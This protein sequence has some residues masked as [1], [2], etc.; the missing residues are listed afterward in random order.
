M[1][2]GLALGCF[3]HLGVIFIRI[4]LIGTT[5]RNTAKF[6]PT[7]M[8]ITAILQL[9]HK[10]LPITHLKLSI[11]D[12]II[13]LKDIA[14]KIIHRL[15]ILKH[16]TPALD[17]D[18]ILDHFPFHFLKFFFRFKGDLLLLLLAQLS[19]LLLRVKE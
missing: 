8:L 10:F 1:G 13:P 14:N 18:N 2:L 7:I 16:V 12:G 4:G 9:P 19:L 6:P 5:K 3:S 11:Q 17:P 15:S